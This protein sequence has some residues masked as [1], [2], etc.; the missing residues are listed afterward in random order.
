MQQTDPDIY[1]KDPHVFRGLSN[2]KKEEK[3][4]VPRSSRNKSHFKKKVLD[5]SSSASVDGSESDSDSSNTLSPPRELKRK[6]VP[7]KVQN[8]K[9]D[10]HA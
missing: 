6:P 9:I 4:E 3:K 10:S 8:S 2:N 5:S 1:L 7:M